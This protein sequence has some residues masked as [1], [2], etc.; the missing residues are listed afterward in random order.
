M[1]VEIMFSKNH[2]VK[3]KKHF[4][5]QNDQDEEEILSTTE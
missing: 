2:Q 4:D 3:R 1:D 5:E